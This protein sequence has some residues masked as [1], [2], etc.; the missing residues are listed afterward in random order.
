MQVLLTPGGDAVAVM[1]SAELVLA[2]AALMHYVAGPGRDSNLAA[3]MMAE[4]VGANE[5]AERRAEEAATEAEG[6]A[7]A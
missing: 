3:R 2:E 1:K 6:A 5:A 4:L 7:S